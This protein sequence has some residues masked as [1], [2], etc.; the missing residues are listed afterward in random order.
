[1]SFLLPHLPRIVT[2]CQI[3][4]PV[5]WRGSDAKLASISLRAERIGAIERESSAIQADF[6]NASIGGGVMSNGRLQEE[7]RFC[8]SPELLISLLVCETMKASESILIDGS[9]QFS[10]YSGYSDSL[11]FTGAREDL[12][13]QRPGDRLLAIDAKF[14]TGFKQQF[15]ETLILRELNKLHSGL[16]ACS[17]SGEASEANRTQFA[18]GNWGCGAFGGIPQVKSLLQLAVCAQNGIN[19]TYFCH[20]DQRIDPEQ[21][22]ILYAAPSPLLTYTLPQAVSF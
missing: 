22:A 2:R 19:L 4:S 6:A 9:I 13:E 20:T 17:S 10:S 16:S 21:I 1:M 3:T 14:F 7:I 15:K 5:D 11:Q 8:I 12:Q 18:S